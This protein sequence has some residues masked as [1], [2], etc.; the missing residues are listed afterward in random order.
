M[1][2]AEERATGDFNHGVWW[3]KTAVEMATLRNLQMGR[4]VSRVVSCACRFMCGPLCAAIKMCLQDVRCP[5][6]VWR[7]VHRVVVRDVLVGDVLVWLS[8]SC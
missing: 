6:S 5:V 2:Q 8:V 4:C 3:A 1:A 7:R